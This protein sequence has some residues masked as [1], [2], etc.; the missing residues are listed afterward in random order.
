MRSQSAK[1]PIVCT[2]LWTKKTCPPR[3]SSRR[4]AS[5]ISA[6]EKLQTWVR[7]ASRSAGGVSITERSRSPAKASWSVR[8]IG[9]AVSVTTSTVFSS[10]L[11]RS[12]WATPKRCSS[13]TTSRPRSRNTDVLLEQP[14]RPDHDVDLARRQPLEHLPGLLGRR[15]AR[16]GLDPHRVALEALAEG[17]LVLL[18][19]DRG[20]D[21]HGDLA[22]VHHDP[23]GGAHGDLRL[24]VAD[25]AADQPVHGLRALEIAEHVLDRGQLI[26]RLLA[27]EGRLE[28]LEALVARRKG[29]AQLELAR[30]VHRDQL[31]R[32]VAQRLPDRAL[33]LLPGG[34]AE[35]VEARRVAVGAGV[36]LHQVEAVHGHEEA[37]V[38]GVLEAQELARPPRAARARRARGRRRSRARRAPGSR[39]V[40][41]WARAST[42]APSGQRAARRRCFSRGPKISSSVTTASFSSGSVK[43]SESGA[44]RTST[45]PGADHRQAGLGS[46]A[47]RDS[48]PYCASSARSRSACESELAESTTRQRC[49]RHSRER[50]DQR[51][52]RALVGARAQQ[53]AVQLVVPVAAQRVAL[54]AATGASATSRRSSVTGRRA[55]DAALE[56]VGRER[57]LLRR[58]DQAPGGAGDV[59]VLERL[60]GVVE[61]ALAPGRRVVDHDQGVVGQIIEHALQRGLEQRRERFG[62]GRDVAAQQ[63]VDQLVDGARGDAL[64]GAP[65]R[66]APRV[67]SITSERSSR[68][69]RGGGA[70]TAGSTCCERWLAASNSRIDSTSS[71]SSSMRTGRARCG[72]NRSRMPPRTA[73]SPRS[74]TI[75]MRA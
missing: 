35:L 34:A 47:A 31:L 43:P 16:E 2:R 28:F 29:P 45:R 53:L 42:A 25:V 3:R 38:L 36:A 10:C 6:S 7:I 66:A 20:G 18:T 33:R 54:D 15:E 70:T 55:C 62:A 39:P 4:M 30:R 68:I 13:S 5:R 11:S 37:R 14:V 69:S 49:S 19:Q 22:A 1:E 32:H 27:G 61:Q 17:L 12:L 74:S 50:R 57:E 26:G 60:G 51:R 24:A 44:T 23:E 65:A 72:G 59:V 46:V 41:S 48:I 67:R 71:P 58:R 75:G 73:S 8:G 56:R 64:R 52:E 40:A 21:Q 63:R 9:V